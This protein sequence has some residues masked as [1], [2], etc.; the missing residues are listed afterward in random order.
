VN[1]KKYWIKTTLLALIGSPLIVSLGLIGSLVSLQII[2]AVNIAGKHSS[3]LNFLLLI[4][5]PLILLAFVWFSYVKRTSL[6]DNGFHVFLPIIVVF[7]YYMLVW[8]L[9]FGLSNYHFND[10]LFSFSS[11]YGLTTMPYLAINFLFAFGG[12]FNPFPL[13]QA[14]ITIITVIT[15][16]ISCIVNK[17][18]I[19]FKKMF[20]RML[21]Y[22]C[23]FH[24]LLHFNI[25]TVR[26]KF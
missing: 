22:S 13:L 5:P 15:I 1:L 6:P 9:V 11:V 2:A 20:L 12:D 16:L 18:H 19:K 10:R 26:L 23:F 8:I 25:L 17:K 24:R 4:F 3:L 7:S 21:C 14:A